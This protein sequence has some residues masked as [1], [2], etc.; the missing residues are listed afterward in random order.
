MLLKI[1]ESGM[2][3]VYEGKQES[4]QRQVAIKLLINDL[5][6]DIKART[7]FYREKIL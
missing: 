3:Y 5:S 4:L 2:E 6:R 7:Q 1:D